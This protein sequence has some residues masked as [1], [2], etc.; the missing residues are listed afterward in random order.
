[1]LQLRTLAG[2]PDPMHP[3][4]IADK[5]VDRIEKIPR[6]RIHLFAEP[7]QGKFR[8]QQ[9]SL[10]TSGQRRGRTPSL[11]DVRYQSLLK[12]DATDDIVTGIQLNAHLGRFVFAMHS[13]VIR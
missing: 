1:M 13:S 6:H 5:I 7:F 12:S 2:D 4:I 11:Q 9:G 8:L 10:S 3:Q